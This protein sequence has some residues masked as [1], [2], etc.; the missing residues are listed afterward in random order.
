M[1]SHNHHY[2]II[3]VG[4][5]FPTNLIIYKTKVFLKARQ[6]RKFLYFR[7]H[8]EFSIPWGFANLV[9]YHTIQYSEGH[10]YTFVFTLSHFLFNTFTL[11][12]SIP[13]GFA[14]LVLYHTIQ[15]AEG[16][17]HT[18]IFTLSLSHFLFNTFTFTLLLS[19]PWGFA[20]LV[21]YSL[22]HHWICRRP[23]SHF[24][25]HTFTF[26]LS[27]VHAFTLSHV[28]TFTFTHPLAHFY[29][30]TFTY[31]LSLSHFH[32]FTLSHFH[33]FTL[34]HFH[35]PFLGD[36]QIWFSSITPFNMQKATV[37][38]SVQEPSIKTIS[39]EKKREQLW[40]SLYTKLSTYGQQ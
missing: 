23:L 13:W 2:L 12:L 9:L 4:C 1:N 8:L 27:H 25:F 3:I 6:R 31:T 30:H 39:N 18:F 20:N 38:G 5:F 11:L 34:S 16:H 17:C 7:S 32:T 10:C 14:D 37:T 19:I 22:S 21:L 28:H 15:Y 35:F 24:H 36:L 26:T 33:T 40:R 29:F